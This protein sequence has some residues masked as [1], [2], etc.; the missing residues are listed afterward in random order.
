MRKKVVLLGFDAGNKYLIRNWAESG[1]MPTFRSLLARGLSGNTMSLPGF[2][3]GATWPSFATCVT[4]AK[5][6]VHS[7][8]QLKPGTY[9]FF[10][11]HAGDHI[12]REPF[13]NH[14]SQSGRRVTVL[15]IP[16]AGLTVNL[17]GVQLVEWGAHDAQYGFVT[18]PPSL[19]HEVEMR[20]GRHPLRGICNEDRDTA[21]YV[22]FRDD[23]VRGIETKSALTRHFLQQSEWDFF[24]Q[25][26]T[27]SH[28]VGHQ[29]WHIHDAKHPRHDSDQAGIVGDPLRH[30][31]QAIDKALGEVLSEVDESAIVIVLVSHGMGYKYGPQFLLDQILLRLGVAVP[32][33]I[34]ESEASPRLRD[35]AD[36]L[37]TWGWQQLPQAMRD[38]LQPARAGMR[39]WI[40]GEPAPKPNPINLA[41]SKCFP[42][43]NNYAHGG[44]RV[45]LEGREPEGKVSAHDFDRFCDELTRDLMDIVSLETGKRVV[46]RVIRTKDFYRGDCLDY[47]P[48][49]LVEWASDAPI[50]S[51]RLHS[52]KLG[53]L[54]GEYRF[55]RSGDHFPGGMFVAYGPGISP[56][57]LQRTVSIMDFGPTVCSLLGTPLP[58]V[59]GQAIAE[60]V[61][62]SLQLV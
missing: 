31:Y 61:E 38:L 48:D 59:D 5:N 55:C 6:S 2:F 28:C 32:A 45:N 51:I 54:A 43:E 56:G 15:D 19:A 8:Q 44:I 47:L 18:W 4:P 3:V 57:R 7:W 62:P 11:C 35:R 60:I 29:C 13:W 22:K 26:F 17:N 25:V 23:L 16:L 42:V 52:E 20:F 41:R 36:P 10:R 46:S 37:L 14:L 39:N 33:D 53:E 34:V 49:L 50:A 21:A 40:D 30:V 24:A 27:E 1:A 12:K 58:H 9:D